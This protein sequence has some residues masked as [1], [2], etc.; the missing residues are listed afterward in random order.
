M[1]IV[2]RR[3]A[4]LLTRP[5]GCTALGLVAVEQG[6][7]DELLPQLPAVLQVTVN[8]LREQAA[9]DTTDG[10]LAA[11]ALRHLYQLVRKEAAP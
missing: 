7:F 11:R 9:N 1:Q 10:I 6:D 4:L 2:A 8:R 5:D 3:N